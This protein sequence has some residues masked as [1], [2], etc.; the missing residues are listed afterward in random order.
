MGEL[1]RLPVAPLLHSNEFLDSWLDHTAAVFDTNRTGLVRHLTADKDACLDVSRDVENTPFGRKILVALREA[2]PE[3]GMAICVP[4]HRRLAVT[5]RQAFCPIC[6]C[7]DVEPYFRS[8]WADTYRTHC[9]R[10]MT[11]LFSWPLI[12]TDDRSR[13]FPSWMVKRLGK[14]LQTPTS[15]SEKSDHSKLRMNGVCAHLVRDWMRRQDVRAFAWTQ[16]VVFET[17]LA[18]G[19][20]TFARL[21]IGGTPKQLQSVVEDLCEL[22][23]CTFDRKWT[24]SQ[25][26]HWSGFLGPHWL[27]GLVSGRPYDPLRSRLSQE[28]EPA[29]RRSLLALAHRTLMSFTVDITCDSNTS[30]VIEAGQSAI[31]SDL[32]MLTDGAKDWVAGRS[33]AWPVVPR[34]GIRRAIG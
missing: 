12:R 27:F 13:I 22:F 20:S 17:A 28:G 21:L 16:Q 15:K 11:P 1:V 26:H 30:Y 24:Q 25:G 10:H 8:E 6:F 2:H 9:K 33:E 34:L 29:S 18:Q 23:G 4:P 14:A 3:A 5:S 31:T 32:A 7:S 19:D